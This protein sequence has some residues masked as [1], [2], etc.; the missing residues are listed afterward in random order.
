M[1]KKILNFIRRLFFLRRELDE[2]MSLIEGVDDDIV[3]KWIRDI[4][5]M[6][7]RKD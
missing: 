3:E 4:K 1:I 7:Q 5:A 2:W 6:R